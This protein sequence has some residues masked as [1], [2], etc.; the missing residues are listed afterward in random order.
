VFYLFGLF[1]VITAWRLAREKHDEDDS[2]EPG[3]VALLRRFLPVSEQYNG[4]K[5]TI[6]IDGKKLFTPMFAVILALGVTDVLFALDSI[7][8]IFGLTKEPFL[9]FT[10]NASRSSACPS[11][12]SC[13]AR[14]CSGWSISRRA[15]RSSS[16]SS[17]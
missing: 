2:K 10:A 15:S 9:V 13:S 16:G 8:A 6:R 11:C 17:G 4:T 14:C 3:T 12:T 1:L 7:P 5:M